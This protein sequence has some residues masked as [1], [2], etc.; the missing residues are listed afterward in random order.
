MKEIERLRRKFRV[1]SKR[2]IVQIIRVQ[3]EKMENRGEDTH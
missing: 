1:Q 3:K 2:F